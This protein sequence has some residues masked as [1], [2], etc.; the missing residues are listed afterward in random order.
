MNTRHKHKDDHNIYYKSKKLHC[1]ALETK[2]TIACFSCPYED[3]VC[4]A[5]ATRRESKEN[6][7]I[8]YNVGIAINTGGRY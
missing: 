4:T 3:C 5:P 8:L 7:E 2:G 1:V 6:N